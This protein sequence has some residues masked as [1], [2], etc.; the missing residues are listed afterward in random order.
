MPKR[1][2]AGPSIHPLGCVMCISDLCLPD[3]TSH[4]AEAH[5]AWLLPKADAD[6]VSAS[7]HIR[8]RRCRLNA[9]CPTCMR[10]PRERP[11]KHITSPTETRLGPAFRPLWPLLTIFR[12]LQDLIQRSSH[13]SDGAWHGLQLLFRPL[14]SIRSSDLGFGVICEL[15]LPCA[16][17]CCVL[18]RCLTYNALHRATCN[19]LHV[20]HRH[21]A[22]QAF[23]P[24]SD[25]TQDDKVRTLAAPTALRLSTANGLSNVHDLCAAA[26]LPSCLQCMPRLAARPLLVNRASPSPAAPCLPAGDL[27]ICSCQHYQAST[28]RG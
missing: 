3:A 7:A 9:C 23:R 12:R 16:S 19:N 25:S 1:A 27:S 10:R 6:D 4:G 14:N 28:V 20:Q 24:T 26:S 17:S 13:I 11:R 15:T 2:H 22:S 8:G 5:S 18:L 21:I